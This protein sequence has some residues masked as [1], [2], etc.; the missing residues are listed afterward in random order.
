MNEMLVVRLAP[1]FLGV[2]LLFPAVGRVAAQTDG[3]F[4]EFNTSMGSFTCRVEYAKAPKASANFIGLATGQRAWLDL[5]LGL[6]K[7]QAFYNG[8]TFHRVIAGFMNQGGSPN[9]QGT[10]GPGYSFVDEFDS[11]LRHDEFGVLSMANSGPDSNGSQFFVTAGPTPWL[12]DVHTIFGKLVGGSNVVYAINHVVTDANNKPL[13]NVLLQSVVIRRVGAAAQAFDIH[14]QGLPDVNGLPSAIQHNGTNVT[15]SF[16]N[17]LNRDNRLYGSTN[18]S[19]WTGTKLGIET[20]SP[21]PGGLILIP[22][23]PQRFYRMAQIS[24]PDSLYVPRNVVNRAITLNFSA[25]Y[26]TIVLQPNGV[27]SGVYTQNG[28]PT[29]AILSYSW[30]QDPYRGRLNPIYFAGVNPMV[31]HLDYDSPN[32]GTFKG[33]AYPTPTNAIAVQGGFT[34]SP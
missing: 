17:S 30:I 1:V 2:F 14:A 9:G 3:I 6:V 11:T 27:G 15:L 24:Y 33:M 29:N 23:A 32:A 13:T 26:G 7:T 25:T 18:L 4:A 8:L 12:N 31:L 34:S 16:S 21:V 10:D 5:P 20:A 28:G 19:T 22:A